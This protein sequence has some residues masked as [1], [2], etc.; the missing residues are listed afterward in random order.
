MD[1]DDFIFRGAAEKLQGR[2]VATGEGFDVDW[3]PAEITLTK[4]EAAA[5]ARAVMLDYGSIYAINDAREGLLTAVK[6]ARSDR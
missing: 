4:A 6:R 1:F 5:I 3:I 2:V